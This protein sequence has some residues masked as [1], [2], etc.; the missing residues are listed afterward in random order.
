MCP[1]QD[2]MAMDIKGMTIGLRGY[3]AQF[4]TSVLSASV[5]VL[6]PMI[7]HMIFVGEAVAISNCRQGG[8]TDGHCTLCE[9]R[10]APQ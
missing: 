10:Q 5:V 7:V 1:R 6:A 8:S 2:E 9:A 4:T 3:I